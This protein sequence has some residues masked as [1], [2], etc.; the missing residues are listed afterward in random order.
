MQKVSSRLME[1]QQ[2]SA[3][4][5][6][7]MRLAAEMGVLLYVEQSKTGG[8]LKESLT[9]ENSIGSRSS[10]LPECSFEE[11]LEIS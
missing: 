8:D 4:S 7:L 9:R 11:N 5:I 6:H 2:H 3:I 10:T 1:L